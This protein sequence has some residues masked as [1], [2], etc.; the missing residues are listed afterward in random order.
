MSGYAVLMMFFGLLFLGLPVA[1]SMIFSSGLY[2]MLSDMSLMVLVQRMG[3]ALN[4]ITLLAVPTF[5]FA[6]CI[7]NSGGLTDALFNSVNTAKIGRAKGGLAYVNVL[8][9]LIFAGMSGAALADLGGLGTVEIKAMKGNGYNEDDALAVTMASSAIGPIFPP[10]IPLLLYAMVASVSGVKILLAGVVPGILITISLCIVVFILAKKKNF[11]KGNI[12]VSRKEK[13][14]LQLIGIPA[15][16]APF[17]LLGGLFN[18]NFSPT[19]LACVAVVYSVFVGLFFYHKINAMVIKEA[20]K[21]TAD[22]VANTMFI[23]GAA[24]VFAFI[25]TVERVP[26]SLANQIIN[27]TSNKIVLI[28]LVNVLLLLVGMVMDVGVSIMIFVP[29]LLPVLISVGCDPLQI[30]VM[31][32]LNSVIGM[33]TPPFGTCLFLGSTMTGFSVEKIVKAMRL[34]YIPLLVSLAFV[35]FIP[36]LS[37]WLPAIVMR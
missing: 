35:S 22:M 6:G 1:F 28:I 2:F 29:I 19:E 3:G 31:M 21:A 32:V 15:L 12:S 23:M 37:T 33:Y 8:A 27:F 10:S 14:R 18:G 17:I 11:P 36:E 26:Q 25:L 7:M 5:I 24:I 34:Y 4:S 16:L 30:G 13:T 9:S 20:A